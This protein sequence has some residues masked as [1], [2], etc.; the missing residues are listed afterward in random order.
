[1]SQ[2]K[3]NQNSLLYNLLKLFV[4]FRF[5]MFYS[6]VE[7]RGVG[8]IPR[9]AAVIFAPNHCNA[10]MDPL[11]ILDLNSGAKVFVAR[12]DLFRNPRLAR[13]LSFFKIMPVLRLRDG[14]ENL[15]RS[16]DT[17]DRAVEVLKERTPFCIFPEA[18]HQVNRTLLPLTKGI[19][20]IALQAQRE[21]KG[22]LYIVPVGLSYESFYHS[23]SNLLVNVGEPMLVEP[24]ALDGSLSE[25][26]VMNMMRIDCASRMKGL[27]HHIDKDSDIEALEEFCA[28]RLRSAMC[29]AGRSM[30]SLSEQLLTNQ[31]TTRGI[32]RLKSESPKDYSVIVESSRVARGERIASKIS[33]E[34]VMYERGLLR[35][36]VGGIVLLLSLPYTLLMGILFSPIEL[37]T[38]GLAGKLA[39]PVFGTSIRFVLNLFLAPLLFLIYALIGFVTLPFYWAVC[40][41]VALLF[42]VTLVQVARSECRR[43]VSDW[44]LRRNSSLR[45][46]ICSLR[47]FKLNSL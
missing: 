24:Y 30:G 5:R 39:D 11:A 3:I 47:D 28:V 38:C 31:E 40:W 33:L 26:E 1:M 16:N 25:A 8:N 37:L 29:V 17:A 15:K 10:L 9:D 12:A 43:L 7:F 22:P 46:R 4:G 21:M 6:R 36:I 32:M 35:S 45:M 27:V 23:R 19:F 34:S 13:L 2:K 41:V 18:A 14:Y 44:R 42:A 20:R